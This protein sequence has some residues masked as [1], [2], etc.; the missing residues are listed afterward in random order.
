MR[1]VE[2]MNKEEM[3]LWMRPWRPVDLGDVEDSILNNMATDGG[4]VVKLLG[5]LFVSLRKSSVTHS[6]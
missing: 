6:C 4:E 5:Q 2:D 1:V 3:Y